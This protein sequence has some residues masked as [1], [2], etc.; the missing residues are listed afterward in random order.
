MFDFIDYT[1]L[2]RQDAVLIGR[3]VSALIITENKTL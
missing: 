2:P 1:S 3:K